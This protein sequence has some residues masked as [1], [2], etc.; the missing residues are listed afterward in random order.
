MANQPQ[1]GNITPLGTRWRAR[2]LLDGFFFLW[3]NAKNGKCP[4]E[5]VE[6]NLEYSVLYFPTIKCIWRGVCF[7]QVPKPVS[8]ALIH[9]R[10]K[11]DSTPSWKLASDYQVLASDYQ[12]SS[13]S[14]K[15]NFDITRKGEPVFWPT[16]VQDDSRFNIYLTTYLVK[17]C[18][19][20]FDN[21]A[22]NW[23]RYIATSND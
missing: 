12:A 1:S 13:N 22:S 10:K 19:Y 21:T 17:R 6:F 5:I 23:T 3:E 8:G 14:N 7:A 2:T 4:Y 16:S 18:G 20:E 15:F 11:N 9:S